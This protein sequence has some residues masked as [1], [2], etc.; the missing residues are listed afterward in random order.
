M[1]IAPR[2]DAPA[3]CPSHRFVRFTHGASS[4]AR[5]GVLLAEDKHSKAS[6]SSGHHQT[7]YA[8]KFRDKRRDGAQAVVSRTMRELLT[9]FSTSTTTSASRASK[10]KR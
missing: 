7:V 9:M 3:P 6:P 2:L 8:A 1:S 5:V 10:R 4:T